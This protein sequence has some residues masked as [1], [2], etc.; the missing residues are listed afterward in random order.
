[1]GFVVSLTFFFILRVVH[2]LLLFFSCL[3]EFGVF[4]VK[5]YSDFNEIHSE[6]NVW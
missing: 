2:L 6:T 1:M 4:L 5:I 3:L